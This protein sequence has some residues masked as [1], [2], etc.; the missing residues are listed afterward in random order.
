MSYGYSDCDPCTQA[1]F[2]RPI[3]SS[4]TEDFSL[5]TTL[6]WT[7]TGWQITGARSSRNG[8]ECLIDYARNTAKIDAFE[9]TT[10]TIDPGPAPALAPYWWREGLPQECRLTPRP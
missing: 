3:L 9:D 10:Y 1:D 7:E 6:R 2:S 4:W 8:F 5:E